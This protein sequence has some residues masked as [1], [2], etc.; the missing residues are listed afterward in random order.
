MRATY[1]ARTKTTS[2]HYITSLYPRGHHDPQVLR[3]ASER[4]GPS[5]HIQKIKDVSEGEDSDVW[6]SMLPDDDDDEE[7]EEGGNSDT[8]DGDGDEGSDT[9]SSSGNCRGGVGGNDAAAARRLHRRRASGRSRRNALNP[10]Y[11][12]SSQAAFLA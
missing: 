1:T 7:E 11:Q 10:E 9:S 8:D 3:E 4:M 12:V 5:I 6:P 2:S